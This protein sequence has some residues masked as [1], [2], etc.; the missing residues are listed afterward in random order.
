MAKDDYSRI[1]CIILAYLY[2]RLRGRTEERPEVYLQPMT[3]DFP[4]EEEYF[5]FVLEEMKKKGWIS[6][7][8]FIKNWG[9]D[10]VRVTGMKRIQITGDGIQYLCDNSTIRKKLEWL[11]DNAPALPGMVSTIIGILEQ[12]V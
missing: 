10:L 11:R 6:G 5:Y 8:Q 1:V 2:A 9:G 12:S 4:V 3:N 7:L